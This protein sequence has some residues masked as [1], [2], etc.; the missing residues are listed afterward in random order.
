MGT[1]ERFSATLRPG[2]DTARTILDALEATDRFAMRAALAP[3]V[4]ARLNI[5]VEE[6]VSNAL[7]HGSNDRGV[8]L[9]LGLTASDGHV[10]FELA[11]DGAEFDPTAERQFG[12]PDRESG[13]GVGLALI[14][15][16]AHETAYAR[17]GE[18]NCVQL[19]LPARD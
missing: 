3:S 6:L 11:D 17:E 8:T 10:R 4:A 15:A 7:R 13:G 18:R 1:V 2:G 14:R 19:T 12:G 5:V 16:W 9:E